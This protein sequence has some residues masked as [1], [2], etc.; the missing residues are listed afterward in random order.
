MKS[1]LLIVVMSLIICTSVFSTV[2]KPADYDKYWPQWRGP[3]A[4]GVSPDGNPPI[5]WSEDKNIK[6]KTQI[7][8]LGH[9]TPI[10]WE[11]QI[12]ILTAVKTEKQ[13]KSSDQNG[14]QQSGRRQS[15]GKTSNIHKFIVLSVNRDNGKILWQRTV[16]EELPEEGIHE[17]GSWASNS[18][19]TDGKHLYAYF[20][21]RGLFCLDMRGKLKWKRDFGQ[22]RKRSDFGEGSSPVIYDNKIIINWDHEGESFIIAIDKKTGGDIWKVNRDEISSWSTPYVVETNGITQVITT[23][24]TAVRSYDVA[25]GKLIWECAGLTSNVIPSPF[26]ADGI[27]Y[28]ASG[29]RG[30]A[31]MAIRLSAAKGDITGTDAIIWKHVK[32]MPYTP[33]LLLLDNMI[34]A[35]RSNKGILSCLDAKDGKVYYEA[36]RLEGIGDIFSSPAGV[37]DR[38]YIVG[39]NGITFVVKHGPKFEILGQ[40]KL[41]DNFSASP[42]I[43]GNNLYL[44]GYQNLYCIAE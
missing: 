13:A 34:Y 25:N 8:G 14:D 19:V 15:D 26:V 29:H 44:R 20:G 2:D 40:N 1:S 9:A 18:P 16:G 4:N 17:V 11:D 30:F 21:S 42:V 27:V 37:K 24:S 10:I 7:P 23:A 5:E 31:L 12:F 39:Q 36:E 32:D 38:F 22:M 28:A 35:L 33:S 43:V 41:D 6:W 3:H